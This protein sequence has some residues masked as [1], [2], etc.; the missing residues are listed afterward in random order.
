MSTGIH[1]DVLGGDDWPVWREIRLR[2]LQD[3]PSAF[4]STYDRELAFAE[5]DWRGRLAQDDAVSVL[6]RDRAGRPVGMGGGYP[7]LPG[8]LHVVAMWVDP[9][10]R[11]QGLGRAVLGGIEAWADERGLRLH[12]DVNT[13]NTGARRCYEHYGFT[14]TG[15]TRPLREGSVDRVERMVLADPSLTARHAAQTAK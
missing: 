10:V 7:D 11:G 15:E 8:F 14:A 6:V 3:S 2:A 9:A 13:T 1:V 5:D 12:L 4:A